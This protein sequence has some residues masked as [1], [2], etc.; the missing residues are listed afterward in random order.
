MNRKKVRKPTRFTNRFSRVEIINGLIDVS[1][2]DYAG[3]RW[4]TRTY[5]LKRAKRLHAWLGKAI[6]YLEQKEKEK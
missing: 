5:S 3:Y 6:E 2:I 4:V 1:I